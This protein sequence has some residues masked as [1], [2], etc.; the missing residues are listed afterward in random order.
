MSISQ[1][2]YPLYY[3]VLDYMNIEDDTDTFST[4][5]I[6]VDKKNCIPTSIVK[7]FT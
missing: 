4:T 2:K 3:H 6:F 1:N 5:L 7:M